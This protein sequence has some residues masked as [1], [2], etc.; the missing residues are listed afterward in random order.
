M[1]RLN[2]LNAVEAAAQIAAGSITSEQLIRACL[3]RIAER[4]SDVCAWAF[5]S[6]DQAIAEARARDRGPRR[7]LLH[8]L[9]I[10]VKDVIDTADMPTE[11]G[12][13]IY[14]GNQPACDAVCV[15]G[16]REQ[17]A[18]ILGKAVST[19]LANVHP[20]GTRNPR[21]LGHTPGGSSSG[22]A[23]AVADCMAPLGFGTQTG[24]S[25]IRPASYCGIVG[26]KPT[27][28]FISTAG[29]KALSASLDTVGVYGR[30][31]PDAALIG[32]ALIGFDALDF[33]AKP[34]AEIALSARIVDKNGKVVAARLFEESE[35]F[36]QV[37]PPEA[38]AAFSDAF[39]RIAKDMIAWT[40][41]AL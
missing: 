3:D 8:G 18:V 16:A 29:V 24:G 10:A 19:E 31:V 12:T 2:E 28:D 14:K 32:R 36:D 21:N 1:L 26:Y 33:D 20:A 41:A 11:H 5:I 4:E 40:V 17:G 15:S 37:A 39:G 7:G 27:L 25:L 38:V 22:P 30:T 9:P 13:P 34:A 35:K 6:P 23:A